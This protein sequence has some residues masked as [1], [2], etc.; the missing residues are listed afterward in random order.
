MRAGAAHLAARHRHQRRHHPRQRQG[1]RVDGGGRG[2]HEGRE[3]GRGA[4]RRAGALLQR[5]RRQLPHRLLRSRHLPRA[6]RAAARRLRRHGARAVLPEPGLRA[7]Q[8][9]AARAD[10]GAARHTRGSRHRRAHHVLLPHQHGHGGEQVGGHD[11]RDGR[12]GGRGQPRGAGV[13]EGAGGAAE[14]RLRDLVQ[15]LEPAGA[16]QPAGAADARQPR[17]LLHH[18]PEPAAGRHHHGVLLAPHR[19]HH[20]QQRV[21]DGAPDGERQGGAGERDRA[22]AARGPLRHL[23][24]Q[25]RAGVVDAGRRRRG[26]RLRHA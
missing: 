17:R 5:R 10:A 14:R 15:G 26:R 23:R 8:L 9:R 21:D 3:G 1:L 4:E 19:V 20:R 18:L 13:E 24:L 7:R 11:A 12:G 6:L 2:R 22:A 25:P 16:V